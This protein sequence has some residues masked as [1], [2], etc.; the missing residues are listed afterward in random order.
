M[1]ASLF[2]LSMRAKSQKLANSLLYK[3]HSVAMS[4][5]FLLLTDILQ[6]K[7]PVSM[8]FSKTKENLIVS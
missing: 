4:A 8:L 5:T 2:S 7:K 3:Y 6:A 1:T